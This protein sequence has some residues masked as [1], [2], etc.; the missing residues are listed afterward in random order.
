MS[1]VSPDVADTTAIFAV[2]IIVFTSNFGTFMVLPLLALVIEERGGT[3][4]HIAAAFIAF[5]LASFFTTPL[6]ATFLERYGLQKWNTMPCVL[7]TAF[8]HL[9]LALAQDPYLSIAGMFV[10]GCSRSSSLLSKTYF[11]TTLPP[12]LASYYVAQS[13]LIISLSAITAPFC[14]GFLFSLG[15]FAPFIA[16]LGLW[17]PS[18]A[19][20]VSNVK[21]AVTPNLPDEPSSDTSEGI[22]TRNEVACENDVSREELQIQMEEG[23]EKV[24]K[25]METAVRGETEARGNE[26]KH[27][28]GAVEKVEKDIQ[29]LRTDMLHRDI[30]EDM[31]KA[32]DAKLRALATDIEAV[33]QELLTKLVEEERTRLQAMREFR[34]E[35]ENRHSTTDGRQAQSEVKDSKETI[36]ELLSIVKHKASAQDMMDRFEALQHEIDQKQSKEERLTKQEKRANYLSAGLSSQSATA[37]SPASPAAAA[38]QNLSRNPVFEPE[39]TDE[40]ESLDAMKEERVSDNIADSQPV[41]QSSNEPQFGSYVIVATFFAGAIACIVASATQPFLMLYAR[42]K[43]DMDATKIS[44][45][46]TVG[47]LSGFLMTILLQQK[48]NLTAPGG[49][50]A[51]VGL[52]PALLLQYFSKEE[53][54]A[55]FEGTGLFYVGVVLTLT[56]YQILRLQW[57]PILL[58]HMKREQAGMTFGK[59]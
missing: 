56:A 44:L 20:A 33:Q 9:I 58:R 23:L 30:T 36:D 46:I 12:D 28:R 16:A 8:A 45:V 4:F 31:R 54:S 19:F 40:E 34:Q 7:G 10:W 15:E 27:T 35:M 48:P 47:E 22:A 39:H 11:A 13:Y 18:V 24:R 6:Y 17:L 2:Q 51:C 37:A 52:V 14:G 53:Q 43:F 42:D 26:L 41:A 38:W 5:K 32:Q 1:D 55:S 50:S 21:V 3:S 57:D 59:H 25:E 49:L 29:V